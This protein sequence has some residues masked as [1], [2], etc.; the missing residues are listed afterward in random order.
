MTEPREVE[1]WACGSVANVLKF[2]D[3]CL[4]G[5]IQHWLS[6]G[7]QAIDELLAEKNIYVRHVI[8]IADSFENAFPSRFCGSIEELHLSIET[9]VT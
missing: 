5:W 1:L 4:T 8:Y 7:L 9:L 3:V 6:A 2:D